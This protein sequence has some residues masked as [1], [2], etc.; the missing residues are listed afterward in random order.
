MPVASSIASPCPVQ[1]LVAP[2]ARTRAA[3]TK[4]ASSAPSSASGPLRTACRSAVLPARPGGKRG[5]PRT[6]SAAAQGLARGVTRGHP[7]GGNDAG[8]LA[9][10]PPLPASARTTWPVHVAVIVRERTQRPAGP[11]RERPLHPR[12]DTPS[13]GS[14][15][16]ADNR[17]RLSGSKHPVAPLPTSGRQPSGGAHDLR[18]VSAGVE[19]ASS[20]NGRSAARSACTKRRCDS[21]LRRS[22]ATRKFAQHAEREVDRRRSHR[23]AATNARPI[24]PVPP[25]MSSRR[26]DDAALSAPRT[27]VRTA[28]GTW[29]GSGRCRSKLGATE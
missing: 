20:R 10:A 28:D 22:P 19:N 4:A 3:R 21:R 25:P 23:P 27:A 1:K 24:R 8:V 17:A 11:S 2:A 26:G 6:R 5:E 14:H 18:S 16:P 29:S 7:R 13:R 12:V 15:R 9:E